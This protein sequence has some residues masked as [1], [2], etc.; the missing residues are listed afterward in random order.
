MTP[1]ESAWER[2]KNYLEDERHRVYEEIRNY[3][4]PIAGCDEQFNHLL[5]QRANVFEE[6]VR[7]DEAR[8]ESLKGE[9]AITLLN[10]FI[11]S[12]KVFD[13]EAKAALRSPLIEGLPERQS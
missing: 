8:E 4:T 12:S 10:G 2:I 1:V 11:A 3:P 7:L 13:D 9:D 5:R 6:L